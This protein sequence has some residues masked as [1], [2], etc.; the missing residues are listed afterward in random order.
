MKLGLF[1]LR[2]ICLNC[3]KKYGRGS[4]FLLQ[5]VVNQ[6]RSYGRCRMSIDGPGLGVIKDG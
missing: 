5:S 1:T 2:R 4:H 6:W 3:W